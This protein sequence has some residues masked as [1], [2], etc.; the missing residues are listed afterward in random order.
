MLSNWGCKTHWGGHKRNIVTETPIFEQT[1]E[2]LKK[3]LTRP[4]RGLTHLLWTDYP[5]LVWLS[6]EPNRLWIKWKRSKP[7]LFHYREHA[8]LPLPDNQTSFDVFIKATVVFYKSFIN[9]GQLAKFFLGFAK[10]I[11]F[12]MKF[13]SKRCGWIPIDR[14]HT[15]SKNG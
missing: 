4:S 8:I 10:V 15:K 1:V 2:C 7:C 14:R 13:E 6:H 12:A 5:S 11:R 9:D 3:V